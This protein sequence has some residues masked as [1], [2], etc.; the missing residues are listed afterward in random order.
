MSAATQTG[1]DNSE[2]FAQTVM[3]MGE[4]SDA[5]QLNALLKANDWQG[6]VDYAKAF[7]YYN[8]DKKQ[9]TSDDVNAALNPW[10][11]MALPNDYENDDIKGSM[12]ALRPY[13]SVGFAVLKKG[14]ISIVPAGDILA[15]N[16]ASADA[17]TPTGSPFT[18]PYQDGTASDW[19]LSQTTN[20]GLGF[21]K[22]S[23]CYC[24]LQN[25]GS[26]WTKQYDDLK[27]EPMNRSN[28]NLIAGS[29]S[30]QAG[31]DILTMFA[32]Y[33]SQSWSV[34]ETDLGNLAFRS[35]ENSSNQPI[36]I[37]AGSSG[38]LCDGT[39]AQYKAED[40][41][42]SWEDYIEYFW[43]QFLSYSLEGLEWIAD[44]AATSASWIEGAAMDAWDW[45]A[46]TASE[47]WDAVENTWSE[48]QG[49]I[50]DI[51]KDIEDALNP[52]KW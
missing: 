12:L 18:V 43:N 41:K 16:G 13:S 42:I 37:A 15:T 9:F 31:T 52:S 44:I 10:M 7:P 14:G 27:Q 36:M 29:G 5:D 48:I 2:L 3:S 38:F 6:V 32:N 24:L 49:S 30:V 33:G 51:G 8:F 28:G 45:V 23:S 17:G 1:V 47:A 25:S 19:I 20:G 26:V 22:A 21:F 34:M 46:D 39:G 40:F 35:Q 4:E 11:F 50:E